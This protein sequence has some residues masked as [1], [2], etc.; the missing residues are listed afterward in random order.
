MLFRETVEKGRRRGFM[1]SVFRI[2]SVPD[3]FAVG[4]ALGQLEVCAFP[5]ICMTKLSRASFEGPA[6]PA[7][8]AE[9]CV[10]S[11]LAVFFFFFF[12]GTT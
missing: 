9:K 2:L 1:A 11:R 5:H 4:V 7:L 12:P 3:A 6:K 10:D 8:Q